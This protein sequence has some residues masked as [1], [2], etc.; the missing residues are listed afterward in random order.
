MLTCNGSLDSEILRG[1]LPGVG[2]TAVLWFPSDMQ[3]WAWYGN[4]DTLS[5]WPRWEANCKL[6]PKQES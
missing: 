1:S 3:A 4:G 2:E 5:R 6:C